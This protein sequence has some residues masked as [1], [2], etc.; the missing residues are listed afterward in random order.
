MNF[1][2]GKKTGTYAETLEAVGL[3]S[4]MGELGFGTV[5]IC[6][7]GGEFVLRTSKD[8]QPG[9][10]PAFIQPGYPYIW[11]NSKEA[12][13]DLP[14]VVNYE[15][16]KTKRDA[17]RKAG[18]KSKA[19]LEAH[20]IEAP[21]PP[22]P[23]LNTAV[24]LASMRKGWNAD[25]DLAKWIAANSASVAQWIQSAIDVEAKP[26]TDL[27]G[28]SN[29]QIL[30]PISGKGVNSSKTEIRSAGSLP[31]QLVDPF[32]EWMKIRGLWKA[33]LLCRSDDDFKFFVIEPGEIDFE[34]LGSV[35]SALDGMNLW[36]GVRLDINATLQCVKVLIGL[37]DAVQSGTGRIRLRRR[38]PRQIIRGLRQAYFKSLGTAAALMNDAFLPL[39]DWFSVE[40][41]EDADAYLQ[42]I[43]ELI[44]KGGCLNSLQDGNS[45][46]GRI[47]QVFREWLLTGELSDLLEFHHLFAP[48]LMRRFS[49]GEWAR[50]FGTTNLSKLLSKTYK[51]KLVTEIIED[52]GFQSVAR[53][54]RNAT[55]YALTIPNIKREVRFG[56]AQKWKQKIKSGGNEFTE[57]L[58]EFVQEYNWETAHR[59]K[60]VGHMVTTGEL[61]SV[62]RL[63]GARGAELV[64]SLLLAYGYARAPKV[65][66]AQPDEEIPA[67]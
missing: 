13:P 49:S 35:R 51:E 47:L 29:T 44:E 23:E 52:N 11:E 30:N 18:K 21:A 28:V 14:W 57:A 24:N 53:A 38:S 34:D 1:V 58:A 2:I 42:I 55:I 62:M 5:N 59:L 48:H 16:E 19:N 20:D 64:G 46:D 31:G 61:D 36:G 17:V 4:L 9:N 27:P 3:A 67:A 40:E 63:V 33:M 32:S 37:S 8:P 56:L 10:W 12:K 45:D 39:P 15:E 43:D 65:D 7:K 41:A 6:D 60:G 25:R 66:A 54:I 50:P 26:P 22:V